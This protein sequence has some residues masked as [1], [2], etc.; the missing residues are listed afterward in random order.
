MRTAIGV[1]MGSLA[2]AACAN[3]AILWEAADQEWSNHEWGL[4]R[5]PSQ[6]STPR[7]VLHALQTLLPWI[8]AGARV[9]PALRQC[10]AAGQFLVLRR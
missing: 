3:A 2:L 6:G 10:E 4:L 1:A 8:P 7:P 9:V 5:R